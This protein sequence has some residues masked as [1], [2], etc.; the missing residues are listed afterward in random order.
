MVDYAAMYA[1][2]VRAGK[3]TLERVPAKFREAVETELSR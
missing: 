2:L 1:A 3:I